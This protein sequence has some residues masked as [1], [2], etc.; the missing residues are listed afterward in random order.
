MS[1]L[2]ESKELEVVFWDNPTLTDVID[3]LE[4]TSEKSFK[5]YRQPS[6]H[7]LVY[8][9]GLIIGQLIR[10]QQARALRKRFYVELIDKLKSVKGSSEQKSGNETTNFK[11]ESSIDYL[12]Y[13]Y[14]AYLP[15]RDL[16]VLKLFSSI[17]YSFLPSNVTTVISSLLTSLH[18][19]AF[20]PRYNIE[21]ANRL[22]TIASKIKGIG[23]WTINS[24]IVSIRE[25]D[26]PLNIIR[27]PFLFKDKVVIRY[28]SELCAKVIFKI[29]DTKPYHLNIESVVPL[30]NRKTR[31]SA[32][33]WRL[34]SIQPVIKILEDGCGELTQ[35][36]FYPF[37]TS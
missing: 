33:L 22:I 6:R 11:T 30:F 1:S 27:D 14:E 37:I 28:L 7:L 3:L 5:Y 17:N 9:I 34:K 16:D 23:P 25:N 35:D 4:E 10:F 31:I 29:K 8:L 24:F 2:A 32:F 12:S 15:E 20:Y 26:S 19:E 18:D 36:D 21:N 13:K